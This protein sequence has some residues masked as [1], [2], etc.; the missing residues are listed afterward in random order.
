[1]RPT[2]L[3]ARSSAA[4]LSC[5][6]GKPTE[7]REGECGSTL[8]INVWDFGLLVVC[9][10]FHKL[11]NLVCPSNTKRWCNRPAQLVDS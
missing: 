5:G 3:P 2:L 4:V 9:D 1:M 10:L 11:G 8:K 7:R 6:V